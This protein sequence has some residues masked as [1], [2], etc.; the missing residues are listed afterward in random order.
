MKW[1]SVEALGTV[2]AA[3]VALIA[4]WTQNKAFKASL[5]A[6]LA[7]KLD[8]RFGL[9]EFKKTRAAAALALRDG[10]SKE[11][12]ED[13]FDFFETVG[14]FARRK[15][16]DAEIVHSFFFYWINFYWITG[17][18]YIANAQSGANLRW[19]DFGDLYLKVLKI[20]EERDRNSE[21]IAPSPEQIARFLRE[22]IDLSGEPPI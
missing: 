1:E 5:S 20:E 21:D 8:D 12:A 11:D 16:L 13:V 15:V 9:P 4:L 14:L 10:V 7:M 19:K 22:E 3:I 18:D 6:D 17:K 2:A